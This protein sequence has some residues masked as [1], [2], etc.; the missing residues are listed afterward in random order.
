M[1][2]V[3][4]LF[5]IVI[6]IIV[7]VGIFYY[8]K[9][10][11][12]KEIAELELRKDEMMNVSI[13]DQ[14]YTLKNMEL[15]GQT[16]RQYETL[17]ANWQTITNFKFTEIESALVGAEQYTE[18]INIVKSKATI[19]EAR[20]IIEETEV[21]VADLN[22]SLTDLLEV[23]NQNHERSEALLERY[24]TARQAIMNHSFDYGPAIETLEK[25]LQY[26][27][28][29]FSRYNE[30]TNNGDHLEAESML[31]TLS[32]DLESLE[33]I[34][35]K[36]PSMYD[37]IKNEYEDMI[38]DLRDGYDRMTAA[39]FKFDQED[40]L[41]Q[42]NQ[43]QEKLNEAKAS[44]KNADLAEA[45]T[46]M[47]KADREIDSM[48][49]YMEAEAEAKHSVGQQITQLNALFE[50]VHENNRYA[51]I[52]VDRIAQS[53]ILHDNELERVSEFANQ[54][55]SAQEEFSQIKHDLEEDKLVYSQVE[56]KMDKMLK[57]LTEIDQNQ[58][59]LVKELT[60][61]SVREKNAKSSLDLFE[62]DMRNMKRRLEKQHLPG[63]DQSYY[64][65]FIR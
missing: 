25:N 11:R 37:K 22:Q 13:A 9:T 31:E 41:D 26:L 40:I 17:V 39:N 4:I 60:Q 47:D 10:Q 43:I 32:S 3:D 57:R 50:Q 16:K 5:I 38:E 62:L 12:K 51:G 6:I 35:K 53:Y 55:A 23:S 49:D 24:N 15:S 44:I 2:F 64:D 59:D 54:I 56:S 58:K 48:Y 1:S 65:L 45:Q 42:I 34:L 36:L 33:D 61:L 8:L 27:E 18:Q 63:L 30:Y 29:N 28:L 7:A 20:E 46:L 19:E 52:E 14:L 21:Q